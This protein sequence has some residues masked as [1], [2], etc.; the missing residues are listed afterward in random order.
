MK[1][2]ILA[3]GYGNRMRPLTD[4]K[5]KTLLTVAGKTIIG[6]ILD[7]LYDNGITD[8]V[9]VTGYRRE[10]LVDY[11]SQNYAHCSIS[12]VH[13]ERYRE[14]NNIY[15]MALAFEQTAIDTDI[16]L[17][18]SDLI[19]EPAV[20]KRL[21]SS[22][23][24]TV[25]LVDKYA[26][27]MDGTVVMV[28][29]GIITSVIP[30]HLQGNKF[31]F[32][33]KYKTL[34]IYKFSR[35]F[36]NSV[37]KNLLTY[38][39]KVINDNCYYELILGILIYMQQ[40]TIYAEILQGEKWAEVDDPNDLHGAEFIFNHQKR[41]EILEEGFGGYWNYGITDFC[42][43]RNMYF[44][45][46]ALLSEIRNNLP[47]LLHNYGSRQDLLNQKLAWLLLCNKDNLHALN[48]AS[49]IY[50]LLTTWLIGKKAL[51]PAP[52][53]GEYARVFPGAK[54]YG[55]HVGIDVGEVAA[56][57][58]ECDVV[59]FVNP[60]NPTGSMID[61]QWIFGF[62]A[63]NAEKTI[64]VDESFIEFSGQTSVLEL[65][66]KSPLSNVIIIK[67]LSK[68]MGMPGLRLGYAYS[69]NTAFND[70]VKKSLPI[71]NLNSIAEYYMEIALKHRKSLS[72][73][74]SN[75]LRDRETFKASL[76]GLLCVE[77]VFDSAANFLLISMKSGPR[78]AAGLAGTLL[79]RYSIYVKD[80]SHKFSD[81][82]GYLRLAVRL[83][84][85]NAMIV[86]CLKELE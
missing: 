18:E 78:Q 53:F 16:V 13:N 40:E 15:S 73:S 26:S 59:V 60:N 35:D 4:S 2:I 71:W 62:A 77:K 6:R 51:M 44:P 68:S 25:A 20:I 32:S 61:T 70:F 24:S 8:I 74:F 3:A 54:T 50:P 37:F 66:E 76:C 69:S 27:G 12:Y 29:S 1:A 17:I 57:S 56:K 67:S 47:K 82:R 14:T 80:I 33:D 45:N 64:I 84:H 81:G 31:D 43:I 23:R 9:V 72:L 21:L 52:T 86:K 58:A 38:Y 36:C 41:G 75:T 11:L 55:D 7:G 5:H 63:R 28:E 83:P 10:E 19:Y 30:P 34:N 48:G 79:S 49:Q 46:A 65:L 22:E 42:F 39:A 85:E